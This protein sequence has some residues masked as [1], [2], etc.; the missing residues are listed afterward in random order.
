MTA[1]EDVSPNSL[2]HLHS[3]T[4]FINNRVLLGAH[5]LMSLTCLWNLG[6]IRFLLKRKEEEM[7]NWESLFLIQYPLYVAW[8]TAVVL[9]FCDFSLWLWKRKSHPAKFFVIS[10]GAA[11]ANLAMLVVTQTMLEFFL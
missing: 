4:N 2:E 5:Y 7:V 10:F 9:I 11:F 1:N 3:R 8:A 6:W